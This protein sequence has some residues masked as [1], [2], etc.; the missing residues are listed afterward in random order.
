MHLQ[1]NKHISKQENIQSCEKNNKKNI[2]KKE[3]KKKEKTEKEK[4]KRKRIQKTD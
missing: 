3:I 2:L 4:R 1:S